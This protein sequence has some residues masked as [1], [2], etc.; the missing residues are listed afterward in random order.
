MINNLKDEYLFRGKHLKAIDVLE[1]LIT[2]DRR[3][4]E[5]SDNDVKQ[6]FM[7]LFN[8]MESQVKRSL[9][10]CALVCVFE[11]A[12]LSF[13]GVSIIFP[14]KDEIR[15]WEVYDRVLEVDSVYYEF[16]DVLKFYCFL[17]DCLE[18]DFIPY[19]IVETLLPEYKDSFK[20]LKEEDFEVKGESLNPTILAV[21]VN[22]KIVDLQIFEPAV[23]KKSI[24][25]LE[26]GIKAF[27][28]SGHGNFTD[29]L[30]V[31][32]DYDCLE[33]VARG[34]FYSYK[35]THKKYQI[36]DDMI[37]GVNHISN[38]TNMNLFSIRDRWTYLSSTLKVVNEMLLVTL[39]ERDNVKII[40]HLEKIDFPDGFESYLHLVKIDN[41]TVEIVLKENSFLAAI[42]LMVYTKILPKAKKKIGIDVS[43]TVRSNIELNMILQL[44]K[45]TF[46]RHMIPFCTEVCSSKAEIVSNSNE[47]VDNEKIKKI[48]IRNIDLNSG[49]FELLNLVVNEFRDEMILRRLEKESDFHNELHEKITLKEALIMKR[50]L[51]S[52]NLLSVQSEIK[53]I[54]KF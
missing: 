11:N 7:L 47:E 2:Q 10:I 31:F 6:E 8:Q 28:E 36:I 43:E 3:E 50:E 42:E 48:T 49:E 33:M 25:I 29:N 15:G 18:R 17:I 20:L 46:L 53:K 13:R 16:E 1:N 27:K 37:E 5:L 35:E 51:E 21:C 54:R 34:L 19:F 52:N 14:S 23:E 39:G 4:S 22:R 30:T 45:R 41:T 12:N 38:S 44:N 9:L 32:T 26:K 24:E 40:E